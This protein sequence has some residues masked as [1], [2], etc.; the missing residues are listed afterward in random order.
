MSQVQG[1]LRRKVQASGD[2]WEATAEI[3]PTNQRVKLKAYRFDGPKGLAALGEYLVSLAR[4]AG[5]GKVLAEVREEDWEQFL[6]RGFIPEGVIPAFFQGDPAY[7]LA[8]FTDPKRQA[9]TRLEQE[10]QILE[11]V[12]DTPPVC[13]QTIDG[14]FD[15]EPATVDDVEEMAHLFRTVFT[16]YPS[17]LFDPGYIAKLIETEEGIFRVVRDGRRI[18]SAAAAEVDWANGHAEMTNCATLPDY[19]GEG[20]MAAILQDLDA[21]MVRRDVPCRFSL[22]RASSHGMNLVLRRL[23][24]RYRGRLMNNCHIMG[25]WEDM[26]IWV[27]HER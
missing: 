4:E 18:V 19:R 23:G 24:Y 26:N 25:D 3:D 15:L 21:E 1:E 17:P 11:Q 10:N 2:G 16:S 27:R 9:S 7:C 20:L 5:F 13:D 12:L 8:Y 6:G 14:R 22:A